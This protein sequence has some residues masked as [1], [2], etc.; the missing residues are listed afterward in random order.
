MNRVVLID[1]E[2]LLYGLRT[3]VGSRDN[4]APRELFV[5]FPYRTLIDEILGDGVPVRIL[6]YGARLKQYHYD[7]TLL[8]KTKKA[9]SMQSR[10]VNNLQKQGI[11]FVKTGYLRARETDPCPNCNYKEWH[12]LEKGVDVGLAVRLVTEA[13]EGNEVV[14]ISADTD[15][16]PAV[17]VA[18]SR[19]ASVIFVGYEYQP[20]LALAREANITRLITKPMV[21]KLMTGGR[22]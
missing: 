21:D 20:V 12:L 15:L 22:K 16:L 9:I 3:I 10:L 2:N 6:F 14:L 19:G 1:G 18:R 5:D 7:E 13:L 17:R 11:S 8:E 4:L